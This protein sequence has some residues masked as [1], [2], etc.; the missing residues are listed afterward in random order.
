MANW[1]KGELPIYSGN[2]AVRYKGREGRDDYS[3]GLKIWWNTGDSKHPEEVEWDA[4]SF[5]ELG[6]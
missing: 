6:V 1:I 3:A 5:R 2:Y 4:D